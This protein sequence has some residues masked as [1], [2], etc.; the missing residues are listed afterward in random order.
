MQGGQEY[1]KEGPYNIH[2]IIIQI[3]VIQKSLYALIDL[4]LLLVFV[5]YNRFTVV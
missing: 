1:I 5:G 2:E 4:V 3:Q